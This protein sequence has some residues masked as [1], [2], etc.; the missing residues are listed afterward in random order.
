MYK[1]NKTLVCGAIEMVYIPPE[2]WLMQTCLGLKIFL[3]QEECY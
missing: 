1:K 2:F 3:T